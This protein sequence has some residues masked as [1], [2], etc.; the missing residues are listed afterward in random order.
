[1][2]NPKKIAI[3]SEILSEINS[4]EN[5]YEIIKNFLKGTQYDL[6]QI[7]AVLQSFKDSLSKVRSLVKAYFE[8]EGQKYD[9]QILPILQSVDLAYILMEAYATENIE[10]IRGILQLC[11]SMSNTK[12][13]DVMSHISTL[14]KTTFTES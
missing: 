2:I 8:M 4:L 11:L 1:M 10:Q 7:R 14:K 3:K 5:E 6:A 9:F 13:E 12:I